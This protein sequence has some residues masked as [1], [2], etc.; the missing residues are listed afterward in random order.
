VHIDQVIQLN[1]TAHLVTKIDVRFCFCFSTTS[2][3]EVLSV[4]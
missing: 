1:G 3:L 2:V 4:T